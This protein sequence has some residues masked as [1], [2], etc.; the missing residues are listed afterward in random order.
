M[1][2]YAALPVFGR[3]VLSLFSKQSDYAVAPA[4]LVGNC[5]VK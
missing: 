5:S 2:I 1:Y 4:R 3:V